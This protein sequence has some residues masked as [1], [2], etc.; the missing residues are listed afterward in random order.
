[1][2]ELLDDGRLLHEVAHTKARRQGELAGVDDLHRALSV[3]PA[4]E[5]E[6]HLPA[7]A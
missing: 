1:M 4:V 6:E 2:I 7:H 5:A 3:R